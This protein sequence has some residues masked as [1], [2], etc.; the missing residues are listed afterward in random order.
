MKHICI[1]Q[2]EVPVPFPID[3]EGPIVVVPPEE[4]EVVPVSL[5]V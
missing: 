1:G 2:E 3:D 5:A 4:E